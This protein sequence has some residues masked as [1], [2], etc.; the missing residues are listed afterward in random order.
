MAPSVA[1]LFIRHSSDPWMV[2]VIST[3]AKS[4]LVFIEFHMA[5]PFLDRT[6]WR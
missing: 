5:Y 3:A 6:C 4:D 2:A 1:M